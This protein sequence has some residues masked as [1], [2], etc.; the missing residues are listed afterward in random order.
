MLKLELACRLALPP[1]GLRE[2]QRE[3]QRQRERPVLLRRDAVDVV[4]RVRHRRPL[5]RQHPVREVSRDMRA[6]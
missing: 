4:R 3:R 5:Q 1:P 2:R 6:L